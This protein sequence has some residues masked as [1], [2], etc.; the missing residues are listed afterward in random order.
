[1]IRSDGWRGWLSLFPSV[2]LPFCSSSSSTRGTFSPSLSCSLALCSTG[3]VENERWRILGSTEVKHVEYFR[4]YLNSASKGGRRKERREG[5]NRGT[6]VTNVASLTL[7]LRSNYILSV[8][9][10]TEE[11]VAAFRTLPSPPKKSLSFPQI[12]LF[13]AS[14][15]SFIEF[16]LIKIPQHGWMKLALE[17][18]TI[19][20]ISSISFFFFFFN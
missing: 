8:R 17:I 20:S 16:F 13:L 1:M 15:L 14:S 5:R 11:S 6:R 12:P 9:R 10:R 4:R 2:F 7:I 18:F 19:N 3:G